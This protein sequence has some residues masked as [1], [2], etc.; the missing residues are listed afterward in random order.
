MNVVEQYLA[1]MLFIMSYREVLT[2]ETVYE[3]LQYM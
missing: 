1:L 2:F 3:I